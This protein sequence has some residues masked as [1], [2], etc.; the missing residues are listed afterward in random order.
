VLEGASRV[1][2]AGAAILE[3]GHEDQVV[4]PGH[5]S[6]RLLDKVGFGPSLRER[7]HV[8]EVRPRK[9]L[10][11]GE[12]GPEVGGH[13]VHNP[14]APSVPH[15]PL[16]NVTANLPIE[17]EELAVYRQSCALLR[18]VDP[19]LYSGEPLRVTGRGPQERR[20]RVGDRCRRCHR[21][22]SG[23]RRDL[24]RSRLRSVLAYRLPHAASAS[25]SGLAHKSRRLIK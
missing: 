24:L 10:H 2:K 4:T 19:R 21:R 20:R 7:P 8:H 15:L 3:F 13:F 12:G 9:A 5:L 11:R 18:R 25:P 23:S 22:L 16:Q 6:N 1:R 14:G 17:G